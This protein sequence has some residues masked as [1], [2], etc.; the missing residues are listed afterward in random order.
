MGFGLPGSL[1]SYILLCTT[2]IF[3]WLK[4]CCYLL[5]PAGYGKRGPP[6]PPGIPGIPGRPGD[7]GPPGSPGVG[8]P[9]GKSSPFI[10]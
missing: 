5:L 2:C 3:L 10:D 4:N 8:G 6:G 1:P 9:P 7:C